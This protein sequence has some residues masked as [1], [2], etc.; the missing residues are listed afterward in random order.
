VQVHAQV[1]Y[2][3]KA[4]NLYEDAGY[5]LQG[6]SYVINKLLGTTWLWDRVRVVRPSSLSTVAFG[7]LVPQNVYKMTVK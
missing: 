4:A 3:G 5:K 1:N 6:S 7:K 2:V